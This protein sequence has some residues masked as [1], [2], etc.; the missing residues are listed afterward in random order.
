MCYVAKTKEEQ[1]K[2]YAAYDMTV[3][4][5]CRYSD[6]GL[7]S[8]FYNYLYESGQLNKSIQ[9]QPIIRKSADWFIINQGY[10]SFKEF[11]KKES[12]PYNISYCYFKWQM[13]LIGMGEVIAEFIIP[14]GT[15]YYENNEG[16]IVSENIICTGK[17]ID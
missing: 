16:E 1:I 15:I 13:F 10:H 5:V 9:L 12:T 2:R 3:Y 8:L 7:L 4:K 6:R 14:K 17:V 11:L